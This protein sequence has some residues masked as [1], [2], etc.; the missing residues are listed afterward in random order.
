MSQSGEVKVRFFPPPADMCRFFT[1]FYLV[2]IDAPDGVRVTDHLHPEW[3]N[4]R[5]HSGDLPDAETAD[6]SVLSGTPFPATGPS[7]KAVRFTVGATRLWG[8]GLLPLGWAKYAAA[9]AAS[10]ANA[11]VDGFAHPAFSGFSPLAETV[12][13]PEP[14][15]EAELARIVAYFASRAGNKID[16]EERIVAIHDA[17]ID[18]DVHSVTELVERAGFS[19]RT[20]E[21]VCQRAFGFSPKL[22]LRRQRFMRSLA[23][24]M[25]DPSLKWIGAIDSH[26]HDQAQFV[27]DFRE[28]MGMTPRQY[29]ALDKPILNGVMHDR[30]RFAGTAVQTLDGPSGVVTSAREAGA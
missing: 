3:A 20:M 25:L 28:F 26:Y 13:G 1:T 2:E 6:G 4:L 27:R 8:V 7:S 19:Q 12:F 10:V 5:F 18:P 22:L 15:C 24:F 23:Q 16:D 29:A 17:L 14:D 30:A 9:P 11:A 21:R